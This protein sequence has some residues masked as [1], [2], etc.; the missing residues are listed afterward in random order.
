MSILKINKLTKFYKISSS[1]K[2]KALKEVNLEI[3]KGEIVAI[4]GESGSGKSTLMNIIGGLDTDYS[5]ELL[6]NNKLLKNF[7]EKELDKY[8]KDEIGFIFQSFN[9]ISHLNVLDNVTIAM[10]LSNVSKTKRIK[11]AIDILEKLGLS[12]QMYKRPNQLS[13]G[14]KQ[15][16]AIARALVNNPKIILADEPTGSLD[17]ETSVQILDILRN[18]SKSGITVIMVTHSDLVAS[19]C[20]RVITISDGEIISEE[21]RSDSVQFNEEYD[22]DVKHKQ[23]LNF[24]SAIKLALNNMKKKLA[25]N[26]LISIGASIGIMSVIVML[27]LGEGVK[28]YIKDIMNEN[29]NPLTIELSKP[30]E[31]DDYRPFY[32][33]VKTLEKEDI[34]QLS[35]IDNLHKIEK[36][37]NS[38]MSNSR[39]NID[40]KN[41]N[42]QMFSTINNNFLLSDLL[43]GSLPKE[44][45]IILNVMLS[46]L[47]DEDYTKAIGKK[48]KV[49]FVEESKM[50][51]KEFTI[52]GI[53]ENSYQMYFNYE[54]LESLYLNNGLEFKPNSVVLTM[55]SED[56]V[57]ETK[58]KLK[59]MGYSPSIQEQ[60]LGVFNEMLDV[61][62]YVLAG[63]AAIS[64]FVSAIMI[65]VVLY[66]SVVERTNEIGVL[67]AIGAR[68]KDIKRIFV[69]EAFLI[70]LF[71][72]LIGLVLATIISVIANSYTNNLFE[73]SVSKI[74]IQFVLFGMIISVLLSVLSGLWPA[75]RAAK[76]DPIESLRHE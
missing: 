51:E 41:Y 8:R 73:A 24:I 69:S 34:E 48:I 54:D 39:I 50:L 31:R 10:T 47:I 68:R 61:I 52:S 30:I 4:L 9:L 46:D 12:D 19:I 44:D 66:I 49:Y 26:I 28:N 16:V 3:D 65:L 20:N 37:F 60:M 38:M 71:S 57:E 36:V 7:N 64:L 13:G 76:L 25:R 45:E 75:S 40:D 33:G 70:G 63:I 15:R 21:I 22:K 53:S 27:S 67:K 55:N 17:K 6:V 32:E 23:N 62:T 5:G 2:F 56:V 42:I 35:N 1:K 43:E 74:T 14:Q 29:L 11:K 18:I 72:G 59:E 58:L